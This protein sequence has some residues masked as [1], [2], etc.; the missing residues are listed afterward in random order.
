MSCVCHGGG[1]PRPTAGDS[2]REGSRAP[3]EGNHAPEEGSGSPGE[4][5]SSPGGGSR[6]PC[7]GNGPPGQGSH[8]PG[9]GNHA[10]EEGSR[11]PGQGS[12]ARAGGRT[13]GG[14]GAG[15]R[16]ALLKAPR[17][18][19]FSSLQRPQCAA[20]RIIQRLASC[21]AAGERV[22]SSWRCERANLHQAGRRA[23]R[24]RR[25]GFSSS[26]RRPVCRA[27]GLSA[28]E[29]GP[30]RSDAAVSWLRRSF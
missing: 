26:V 17:F 6:A 15:S 24:R 18:G 13:A 22:R 19:R 11:S 16:R 4:G 3:G 25:K 21:R 27:C 7:E 20:R 8:S 9:G 2:P 5:S 23:S 12:R 29:K 10:P 28:S 30:S 14:E 1:D